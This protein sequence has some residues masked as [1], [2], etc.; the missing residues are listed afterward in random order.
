MIMIKQFS[1]NA[2]VQSI[3][4]GVTQIY[5]YNTDMNR[6]YLAMLITTDILQGLLFGK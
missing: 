5:R 1:E 2:R 3:L 4:R 6:K